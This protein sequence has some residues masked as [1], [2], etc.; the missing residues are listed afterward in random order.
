MADRGKR[1]D[2][3]GRFPTLLGWALG[4]A[5]AALACWALWGILEPVLRHYTQPV[6]TP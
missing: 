1:D 2:E 4:I 5:F 6:P 3:G